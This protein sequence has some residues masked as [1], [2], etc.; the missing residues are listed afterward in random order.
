[1]QN[2]LSHTFN[3]IQRHA[4]VC[5]CILLIS[6]TSCQHK[7]N[8]Q[9]HFHR[10]E[11]LLF[12]TP[13]DQLQDELKKHQEEYNTEL[14][15]LYPDEP[16]YMQMVQGYTTDP[17]VQDIYRITD[18]LYHDLSDVERQLGQALERAYKLYPELPRLNRFYTLV[19]GD[20]D[21][22]NYRI[23]SN[24]I[25]LC[26]SLDQYALPAMERYQYFGIPNHIVRLCTKE[27]IVPDCMSTVAS[28]NCDFP[29][30]EATLLDHTIAWGKILYFIEKTMP[31]L[32][33]TTLLRYTE[34]QLDWMRHNTEQVWSYLIQNRL[35]YSTDQTLFR[36]LIDD[37]PKT[38]AFGEGSAPRTVAYIGWQIV[39][40]YMKKSGATMQQLFKETD[41]QLILTQSAWRP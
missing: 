5:L 37:A 31:G 38:N 40:T 15:L 4:F 32:P 41:S 22:Y 7:S 17:I 19:T 27:Q 34:E 16:E 29:D 26:V 14:I 20:F 3:R 10:F 30:G 6:L 13:A 24:G 18:S 39:S 35:L 36:N 28:L 9:V 12:T 2:N 11:Q 8:S 25:D 1:M 23:Y 33:D 21:N